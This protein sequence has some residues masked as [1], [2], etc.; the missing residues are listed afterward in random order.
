MPMIV[1]KLEDW[2]D[3]M[4]EK[5]SLYLILGLFLMAILLLLIKKTEYSLELDAKKYCDAIYWTEGD[6]R[7]GLDKKYTDPRRVCENTVNHA[8]RDH[9]DPRGFDVF[10]AK[11]YCP[12]NWQVWLKN[13]RWFL[14]YPRHVSSG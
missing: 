12:P 13:V 5:L 2:F 4:G 8:K 3:F 6:G 10:L 11:R 9:P 7:Y 1:K 14:K